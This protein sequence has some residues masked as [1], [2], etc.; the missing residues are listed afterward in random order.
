MEV[1][2]AHR[3]VTGRPLV[4]QYLEDFV[5]PYIDGHRER[6]ARFPAGLRVTGSAH[7]VRGR[8]QPVVGDPLHVVTGVQDDGSR[9]R[10]D[11]HPFHGTAVEELE[12]FHF[13]G[14]EE[15]EQ[16]HILV[17]EHPAGGVPGFAGQRRVVVEP[18]A[19]VGP[20]EGAVVERRVFAEVFEH[21][22]HQGEDQPFVRGDDAAEE[23]LPTGGGP[24]LP[25][26]PIP[27]SPASGV[28]LAA[29]ISPA[30]GDAERAAAE[31][32]AFHQ[33]RM[34][35]GGFPDREVALVHRAA[36]AGAVAR[37]LLEG[38]GFEELPRPPVRL[39]VSLRRH[40]VAGEDGEAG[41]LQGFAEG[42]DAARPLFRIVG[43]EEAQVAGFE[44]EV[45][46][47]LL[48]GA[49][50][51]AVPLEFFDLLV[52]R[53]F[54]IELRRLLRTGSHEPLRKPRRPPASPRRPAPPRAGPAACCR[55][56]VG[57]SGLRRSRAEPTRWLH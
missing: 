11:A 21:G 13:G 26:V 4:R 20:G 15:G 39:F 49:F 38:M 30:A 41:V 46:V 54:P 28:S 14:R 8:R 48:L 17:A 33:V 53:E 5:L 32:P 36:A 1:L 10:G 29:G 47:E 16:V 7:P 31:D 22:P 50:G 27:V 12:A 9:R 51:E 18:E 45:L 56:R 34:D 57:G 40:A 44:D 6:S 24:E 23:R 43:S 25:L 3:G 2:G 55:S 37:L 19:E 35:H 52:G 42:A